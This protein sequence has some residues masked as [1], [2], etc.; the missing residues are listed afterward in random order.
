[1]LYCM[2]STGPLCS[3]NRIS[4]K[5]KSQTFFRSRKEDMSGEKRTSGHPMVQEIKPTSCLSPPSSNLQ[6]TS[7][8]E[9]N[10]WCGRMCTHTHTHR[11]THT[12]T[13]RSRQTNI[14]TCPCTHIDTHTHTHTH[15]QADQQT[16]KHTHTHSLSQPP[17]H[18]NHHPHP[19]PPPPH[20]RT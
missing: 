9:K 8:T 20:P 16:D 17:P 10:K 6:M 2:K 5:A 19:P 12:C 1:M 7:A 18:T 14:Q 13:H 3:R 11:H 15:T 4:N